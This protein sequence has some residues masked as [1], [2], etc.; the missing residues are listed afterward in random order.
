MISLTPAGRLF[1]QQFQGFLFL[2][3][4]LVGLDGHSGVLT[5]TSEKPAESL[6]WD[7]VVMVALQ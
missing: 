2:Q 3:E 7:L 6:W 1:T 5:V 4:S